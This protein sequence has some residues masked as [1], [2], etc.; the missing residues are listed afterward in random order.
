MLG[1][2]SLSMGPSELLWRGGKLSSN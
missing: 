1:A 2:P